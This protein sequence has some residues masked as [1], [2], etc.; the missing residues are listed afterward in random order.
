M[1]SVM[2]DIMEVTTTF[3][4]VMVAMEVFIIHIMV[5]EGS[6]L[7]TGIDLIMAMVMA[8]IIHIMVTVI[9]EITT[10]MEEDIPITPVG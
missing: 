10:L 8:I 3:T 9:M 6:I 2:K 5:M 1:V 7:L 4:M